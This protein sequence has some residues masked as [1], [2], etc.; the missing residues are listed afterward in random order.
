MRRI[1][2]F[3]ACVIT[4]WLTL[5]AAVAGQSLEKGNES[6]LAVQLNRTAAGRIAE[7]DFISSIPLLRKATTLKPDFAVAWYNL[8]T[9]YYFLGEYGASIS[10]LKSALL[11]NPEYAEAFNQ[12]GVAYTESGGHDEAVVAFQKA[13][14]L[15]PGYELA[16]YNLGCVL[17]RAKKMKQAVQ[18]LK[19]AR[20]LSP[21]NN[22]VL[23]NLGLAYSQLKQPQRAIAVIREAL[24][25]DPNDE[26]GQLL[27]CKVLLATNDRAAAIAIYHS[28][29]ALQPGLERKLYQMIFDE[30]IIRVDTSK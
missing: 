17:I 14:E 15:R 6:N 12:L 2:T 7:R 5:N 3:A 4:C 13:I 16:H 9:A 28:I 29:K 23:I 19:K 10:S 11:L 21:E 25:R 22:D 8:G 24:G 26:T 30:K 27:L 1:P 18:V 20:S